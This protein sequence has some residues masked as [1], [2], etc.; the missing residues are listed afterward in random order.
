MGT[1]LHYAAVVIFEREA[2]GN[3]LK[4]LIRYGL[5]IDAIDNFGRPALLIAVYANNWALVDLLISQGASICHGGPSSVSFFSF[6]DEISFRAPLYDEP[7]YN[8]VQKDAASNSSS[9]DLQLS[10]SQK[11]GADATPDAFGELRLLFNNLLKDSNG[12][13]IADDFGRNVLH[14]AAQSG[15]HRL[16][17]SMSPNLPSTLR[18]HSGWTAAMLAE[19]IGHDEISSLLSELNI[20]DELQARSNTRSPSAWNHLQKPEELVLLEDC[21]IMLPGEWK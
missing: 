20:D 13:I 15:F 17:S 8:A 9:T 5:Q 12:S 3:I 14:I 4:I 6:L 16:I 7:I 11:D 10:Q 18:D 19:C 2:L 1:V 21:Q